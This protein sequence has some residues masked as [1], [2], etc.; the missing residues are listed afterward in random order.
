MTMPIPPLRRLT[1]SVRIVNVRS[2]FEQRDNSS[3]SIGLQSLEKASILPIFL[4]IDS[5][6]ELSRIQREIS[7]DGKMVFRKMDF[8]VA[9]VG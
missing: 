6:N 7:L 8:R 4:P 3:W 5:T 9:V 2:L 1:G